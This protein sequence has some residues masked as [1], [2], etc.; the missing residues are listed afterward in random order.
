MNGED[1]L[2]E[3]YAFHSQVNYHDNQGKLVKDEINQEMKVEFHDLSSEKNDNSSSPLYKTKE[4]SHH[5]SKSSR[6][7]ENNYCSIQRKQRL[8][9]LLTKE[10]INHIINM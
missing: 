9:P 2:K 3:V 7:K 1:L 6:E 5:H 4:D 8:P 10:E